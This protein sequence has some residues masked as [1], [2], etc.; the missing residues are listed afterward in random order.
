M[1]IGCGQRA[2]R[3]ACRSHKSAAL[4]SR[5]NVSGN[6]S[7]MYVKSQPQVGC[8]AVATHGAP[9]HGDPG[10]HRR[11]HKSAALRSRPSPLSDAKVRRAVLSQPQVGCA[12]VATTR[13]PGESPT[14]RQVAATSRL[15]FRR[16]VRHRERGAR[17]VAA[18]SRL[19]YR[20]DTRLSDSSSAELSSSQPQVGCAAVAT[21]VSPRPTRSTNPCRSHK[22]AA[23]RS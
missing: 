18:T 10:I 11:S 8:A 14:S 7:T 12:S 9:V 17:H 19:R 23:L 21:P 4:R 15:R 3:C 20:R 5:L 22:S 1:R 6:T 2:V 16:D 13:R